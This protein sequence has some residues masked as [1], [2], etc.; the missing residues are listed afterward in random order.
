VTLNKRAIGSFAD[1]LD[2]ISFENSNVIFYGIP[3]D[4]S[5]RFGKCAKGCPIATS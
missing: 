5:T 2:I 4:I 1:I 3:E